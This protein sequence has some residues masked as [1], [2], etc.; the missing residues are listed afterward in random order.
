MICLAL[1]RRRALALLHGLA[2][3]DAVGGGPGPDRY[4][5]TE[6]TRWSLRVAYAAAWRQRVDE[7][8]QRET[9]F[10]AAVDGGVE[11]CRY[12]SKARSQ[13]RLRDER[14]DVG[15]P[16]RVAA[17]GI[18]RRPQ[19]YNGI[20]DDVLSAIAITHNTS[21]ALSSGCAVAAAMA[22]LL[23]GWDLESAVT[24]SLSVADRGATFGKRAS[25][26]RL[27]ERI[28]E[29]IDFVEDASGAYGEGLEHILT[30]SET[31]DATAGALALAYGHR[32]AGR[33]ILDA[34]NRS[35]NGH[36][37]ASVAGALCAAYDPDSLPKVWVDRIEARN[38]LDLDWLVD[39]L[40]SIRFAQ[41]T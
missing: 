33:A 27:S 20:I 9:A 11:W 40:L 10:L 37:M 34:A 7:Q 17:V 8:T 29:A 4:K 3:G 6:I 41:W 12:A 39:E 22:A 32:H 19:D 23:D 38:H 16:M 30:L 13:T 15:G 18:C 28:T 24:L 5:V 2:A 35:Q 31:V 26:L 25:S 14:D 36:F 21:L 1:L